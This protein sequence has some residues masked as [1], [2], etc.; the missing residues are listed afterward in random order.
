VGLNFGP[1]G[2]DGAI[3][4]IDKGQNGSVSLTEFIDWWLMDL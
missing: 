3:G 4:L 2:L 1:I